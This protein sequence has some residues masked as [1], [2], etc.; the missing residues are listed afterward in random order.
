MTT[1]SIRSLRWPALAVGL[2]PLAVACSHPQDVKGVPPPP[3]PA[4][5]AAPE[6]KPAVVESTPASPNLSVGNDLGKQ[7]ALRFGDRQQAP[8]FDYDRFQLLD[9]DRDVLDQVAN[10]LTTG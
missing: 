10:C 2:V 4:A 9:Q 5:S 3:A 8:K 1:S 6:A 7:C